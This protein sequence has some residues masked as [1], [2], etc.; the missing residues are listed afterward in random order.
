MQNNHNSVN[1]TAK[2]VIANVAKSYESAASQKQV[3]ALAPVS[4]EINAGEF[5]VFVG[6]SGCGKT[7]LLNLIGG[8]AQPTAGEILFEGRRVTKPGSDRLV[9]FQEPALFPWLNVIDNVSYGLK[10]RWFRPSLRKEEARRF[11]QMV[12]LEKFEDARIHELSGGMKQ[13]VALARALAPNPRLLL[14]DEPFTGLDTMVR[15]E[16]YLELQRIHQETRKTIIFVTHEMQEAACLGDRIFVF[17]G[18]P[19]RIT[20]ELKIDLPHPRD[21]NDIKVREFATR[22]LDTLKQ[23]HETTTHENS[24]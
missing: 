10:R 3:A 1:S 2:L 23:N 19:G 8:F 24:A 6:P 16:L 18:S 5:A 17:T 12:H 9:M 20:H 21:F 14:I 11:L 15:L 13:R 7:T 4:L 22:L